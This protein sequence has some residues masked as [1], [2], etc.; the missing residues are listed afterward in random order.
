MSIT[1]EKRTVLLIDDEAFTRELLR[2]SLEDH[3]YN[4]VEAPIGRHGIEAI[5]RF[6]PDLVILDWGATAAQGL[7]VLKSIRE[8]TQAPV[9][10][11]SVANRA[12][13]KISALDNGADDYITKPFNP[14]EVLARVRVAERHTK[15]ATPTPV[16][17][18]GHLSVDRETRTVKVHDHS[19]HLTATEYSLLELFIQNAGKVLTRN[20]ILLGIWGTEDAQ[21]TGYLRVYM[22]FLR[23]KIE[24]DPAHPKLLVTEPAVGYRL[25]LTD[26]DAQ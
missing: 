3:G 7:V 17:R 19:V 13:E 25:V 8:W 22:T 12:E 1:R 6:R 14:D 23:E 15:T 24:D 16:F 11:V 9:L 21:K 20:Q 26:P 10:V 2:A 5:P 4:V 18:S